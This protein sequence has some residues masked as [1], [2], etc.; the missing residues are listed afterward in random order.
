MNLRQIPAGVIVDNSLDEIDIQDS[1]I[2]QVV[3]YEVG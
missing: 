2:Y 1:L 3:I